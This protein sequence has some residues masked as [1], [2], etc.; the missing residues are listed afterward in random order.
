MPAEM[1]R[2]AL[3]MLDGAPLKL[4]VYSR[5]PSRDV[6]SGHPHRRMPMEAAQAANELFATLRE[7]DADDVQLIWVE[8][9]ARR[10]RVGRCGTDCNA[11][12]LPD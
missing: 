8:E 1:L 10:A 11:Q 3:R 12:R 7:L 2:T 6:L 4:A 5:T 9:P